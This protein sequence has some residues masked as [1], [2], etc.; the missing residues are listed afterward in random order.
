MISDSIERIKY[1]VLRRIKPQESERILIREICDDIIASLKSMTDGEPVIAGSIAK[2]TFLSGDRDIDIFVLYDRDMSETEMRREIR[3]LG[4]RAFGTIEERYAQH[5][6]VHA[7]YR[8]FEV[9]LVPAFRF[10][11]RIKSS[12]DRTPEHTKFVLQHTDERMRDEIRILKQFAKGIGVYGAE[13]RVQ[14]LSGYLCELF[15]IRFGC[16][17]TFLENVRVMREGDVIGSDNLWDGEKSALVFIDPVDP[18]R[19]VAAAL[20]QSSLGL[21]KLAAS[22]FL[23]DPGIRFFFPNPPEGGYPEDRILA[24]DVSETIDLR[25]EDVYF[26]QLRKTAESIADALE[27]YG[28]EKS[29]IYCDGKMAILF[30]LLK[31]RALEST[32]EHA[33]PPADME[34]NAEEFLKKW[35]RER[36]YVRDGRLYARIERDAVTPEQTIEKATIGLGRQMDRKKMRILE[37]IPEETRSFLVRE[38]SGKRPWEF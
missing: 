9:D 4:M 27:E 6:Y 37:K 13:A 34:K 38:F 19:N 16:F 18:R 35:G 2:D 26:P 14:G 31:R 20:S 1:E 15:I 29:A 25:I 8:G 23:N 21:L 3:G 24:V 5:P 30:F 22:E 7:T 28:V 32:K 12:V 36:C 10:S 17:E 33:G 11:G